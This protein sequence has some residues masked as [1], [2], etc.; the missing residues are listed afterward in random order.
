MTEQ[1]ENLLAAYFANQLSEAEKA[2]FLSLLDTD[3][4]FS[5]RF[6]EMEAAYVAACIPAFE[7]TKEADYRRLEK[8]I[9]PR[10]ILV[11]FWRPA[12]IAAG[13]AAVVALGAALYNGRQYRDAERFLGQSLETTVSAGRGTGTETLLPDGT[14]V[15]I[16][17]ASSLRFGRRFGR[18]GRDVTLEG[19]GFFEV[20]HDA[21]NPFRVHAGNTCVTVKGTVFNVR[22]YADEP[23]ITV[24][25]LE[26]SVQLTSPSGEVTLRPGTCALVSRSDGRIRLEAA[27]QSVSDW[28]RG[29]IVFTD[30]S[31]PEILNTVERTYGVHF[32]F[33]EDLFKGERFTGKIASG[34]SIDEI[35]TYLDVDHKYTWT[36]QEDTIEIHKK[37]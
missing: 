26:G 6:R 7:K 19:E 14:R 30:K 12:A 4:E 34:L 9:R 23:E 35:L 22:S 27:D 1:H 10:R 33:G 25:L 29:R 24:S 8:Q 2:E 15:C 17:A 32:V 16:N 20:A 21:A 36:R 28:T 11:S 37:Q 13:L 18:G 3:E 5:T 31:I